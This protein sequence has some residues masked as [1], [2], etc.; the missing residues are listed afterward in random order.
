MS[1]YTYPHLQLLLRSAGLTI[2]EEY[3]SFEGEPISICREMIVVARK[4]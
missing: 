4:G 3:G 1:Y 2:A